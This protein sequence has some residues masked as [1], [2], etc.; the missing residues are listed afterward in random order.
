MQARLFRLGEYMALS[1]EIVTWLKVMADA[2]NN[3]FTAADVMHVI[4]EGTHTG[5]GWCEDSGK[6]VG[7]F[8]T[9]VVTYGGRRC[10]SV[11]GAAG[12]VQDAWGELSDVLQG[13]ARHA[14][15]ESVEIRGREGFARKFRDS[16]WGIK[17]VT[18]GRDVAPG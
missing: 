15:C 7:M 5:W 18:I 11:V 6:T 10:L 16:G 12:D 9:T 8:V 3:E 4:E 17:F 13:I 14:E 1:G 2:S